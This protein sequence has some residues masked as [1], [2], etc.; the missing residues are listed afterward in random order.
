MELIR[1][2]PGFE[3]QPY[4]PV[5]NVT[6]PAE[7]TVEREVSGYR[8]KEYA[9]TQIFGFAPTEA[10]I[11]AELVNN[12][13]RDPW[14]NEPGVSLPAI[15]RLFNQAPLASPLT[16]G[17][18]TDVAVTFTNR[19]TSDMDVAIAL[20]GITH[21]NIERRRRR[22]EKS[23]QGTVPEP[24]FLYAREE[25]PSGASL[26][27]VD[28][29]SDSDHLV[30]DRF[31]LAA[32]DESAIR[33]ELEQEGVTMVPETP[34]DIINRQFEEGQTAFQPFEKKAQSDFN[35][36][37]TNTD[38]DNAHEVSFLAVAYRK[39]EIATL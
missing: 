19:G 21:R 7:S 8:S 20:P 4:T 29:I 3:G 38:A 25:I 32:Q 22:V 28:I 26:R 30:F 1:Q 34:I 9:V 6:V 33:V 31:V 15:N 12:D 16:I 39:S 11:V 10:D 2:T 27:E 23:N 13:G 18:D 36:L 24:L 37:A 5:I 14:I 35:L 17:N